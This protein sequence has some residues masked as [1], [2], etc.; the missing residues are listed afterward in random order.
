MSKKKNPTV[1]LRASDIK[2]MEKQI[3]DEAVKYALII[4]LNVMR[5]CE[6]YGIKRLKRVYD[7]INDLAD[8]VSRGYCSLYDLEKVLKD[9][10]DI[11]VQGGKLDKRKE[12]CK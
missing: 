4:F 3:A 2:R 7:A 10:A 1:Q 5:D 9:E 12:Q 6:G 8:S 11:V